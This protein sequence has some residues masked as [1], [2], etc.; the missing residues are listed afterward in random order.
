MKKALVILLLV[1]STARAQVSDEGYNYDVSSQDWNGMATFAR[2][3]GGV[4]YDVQVVGEVE[5]DTIDAEDVLVLMYPLRHVDPAKVD[6]FVSAGGHVLI[7]DDFGEAGDA[8]SGLG[9]LRAELGTP[10]A[11]R[12]QDGHMWAPVADALRAGHPITQD[13][14]EVVCNHPAVLTHVEGAD[15]IVGFSGGDAVIV[16]GHRG[17]GR[18]VVVSDPSIFINKMQQ[19]PGNLTV[20]ANMLRWLDR[21]G[22]ATRLVLA[23]GD[24]PMYGDPQ[25]FIDDAG[26]SKF[27]RKMHEI[28]AFLG[29]NRYWLLTLPAMRIIGAILGLLVVVGAALTLPA[30]RRHQADGRW[31]RVDRPPRKDDL[32]RAVEAA[33]AGGDNF[34]IAATALRDLATLA[35]TRITGR[36]DPLFLS[37]EAE[38]VGMVTALRGPRAGHAMARTYRRLR[39]LPTRTQAAAPWSGAHMSR[40][41]FELL[42]DDVMDLYRS[43]DGEAATKAR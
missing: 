42:H 4:G 21:G 18:F 15:V 16:A 40:R 19:F 24:V 6:A 1:A 20:T 8:M 17:T 28:N 32:E 5:W 43:L 29:Q 34:V 30:W 23:M 10:R 33:D 12:Y 9:L 31:L 37:T 22:R 41:D 39:A 25:P 26:A 14:T 36:H 13:V 38:L 35:L 3:A 2:V 27:D 11:T 7:A